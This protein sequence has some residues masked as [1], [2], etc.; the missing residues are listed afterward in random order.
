M[1]KRLERGESSWLSGEAAAVADNRYRERLFCTNLAP[2]YGRSGLIRHG[3]ACRNERGRRRRHLSRGHHHRLL[4]PA[5]EASSEDSLLH[6]CYA[7]TSRVPATSDPPDP[8][9]PLVAPPSSSRTRA[10]AQ[11][12]QSLFR[13]RSTA[14][15]QRP[16]RPIPRSRPAPS[17]PQ[18]PLRTTRLVPIFP[19]DRCYRRGSSRDR[20]LKR[21]RTG[22]E[23]KR[24]LPRPLLP[25]PVSLSSSSTL[26]PKD[27]LLRL[28]GTT[29]HAPTVASN[30]SRPNTPCRRSARRQQAMDSSASNSP[31]PQ[32]GHA[33]QQQ[34]LL[35]APNAQQDSS[36]AS[37]QPQQHPSP[38]SP[39][40][41]PSA[42]QQPTP[43]QAADNGPLLPPHPV[44]SSAG[45]STSAPSPAPPTTRSTR[46]T[47]PPII[48]F[49]PSADGSDD[50]DDDEEGGPKKKRRA[51]AGA[52][53]SSAK[54]S[55][56][57]AGGSAGPADPDDKG[58][59][60]IEIEYIQK[61]EKR[62]ITFS[63]R[64][65]G[66]MKKAY[67]LATLTG[68][69]VL[70]L[71][72]SET[73]I[74]YTFTTT[75]FQ[76]LVSANPDGTPSEGQK[77]IQKCLVRRAL[78]S[79]CR[80]LANSLDCRPSPPTTRTATTSRR[81]PTVLSSPYLLPPRSVRSKRTLPS[82]A[83]RSPSGRGSIV[84]APRPV[85][86]PSPRRPRTR[87]S[88]RRPVS[89]GRWSR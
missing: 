45:P 3:R 88:S 54:G 33:G 22:D 72:V 85:L 60:K 26:P 42:S 86:R 29:T 19:A 47:A 36:Q 75:K 34:P 25:L 87:L 17:P 70:L 37:A 38:V 23:E 10:S 13:R 2:F 46:K 50:D 78:D 9:L 55:G 83:A 67:E 82:M 35:S 44:A 41:P 6:T 52:R 20:T 80:T 51:T 31:A 65:A 24:L 63:K 27:I 18:L 21:E 4:A 77:L 39:A 16:P 57:E 89:T 56:N 30:H 8:P 69:E 66:I 74:V 1:R 48:A 64:K 43:G 28:G 71:V 79:P 62:H 68:T 84:R 32:Q 40:F 12:E 14:E 11:S 15:Q 53:A 58:R 59:R 76:T 73:G 5:A 7:W 61:K 49:D 81:L